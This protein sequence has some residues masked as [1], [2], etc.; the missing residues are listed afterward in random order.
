MVL[1]GAPGWSTLIEMADLIASVFLTTERSFLPSFSLRNEVWG[2]VGVNVEGIDYQKKVPKWYT[3]KS[4]YSI[5]QKI[6]IF[7]QSTLYFFTPPTPKL[8]FWGWKLVEMIY[9]LS[10][11]HWR[12]NQPFQLRLITPKY[13]FRA[14]TSRISKRGDF[15]HFLGDISGTYHCTT[16]HLQGILQCLMHF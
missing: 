15:W 3:F 13:H 10:G 9:P 4:P 6:V 7:G 5:Y 14:A 1:W 12:L 8:N 11:T 2:S 16:L